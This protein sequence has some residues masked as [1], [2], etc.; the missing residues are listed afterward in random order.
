V[1]RK[2][3]EHRRPRAWLSAALVAIS[4]APSAASAQAPIV[5]AKVE[6]RTLTR[7]LAAEIAAV[8]DRGTA[9]W[10]GYRVPMTIKRETGEGPRSTGWCCSRCRLEPPTHLLVMIRVEAKAVTE[11]RPIAI[12]CDVD[13]SGM[14]LVWLDKVDPEE[15]VAWLGRYAM[16]TTTDRA[17][18]RLK[19]AAV[20]AITMHETPGAFAFFEKMLSR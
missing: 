2:V 4:L 3:G 16:S 13:A 11:V 10:I 20:R 18:K 15:S 9:A 12:D 14:P 6:T 7:G 1:S 8:A 5:N 19:D 17:D